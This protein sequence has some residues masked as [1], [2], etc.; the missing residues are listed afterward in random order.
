MEDC[1][2]AA[3]FIGGHPKQKVA[4]FHWP[5]FHKAPE[6]LCNL[7]FELLKQGKVEPI[8]MGQTVNASQYKTADKALNEHSLDG[9][10]EF[11]NL[12]KWQEL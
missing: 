9:Y 3:E 1:Q 11:I 8:V 6:A 10:P 5:S 2:K 12:K 7:Y 4:L